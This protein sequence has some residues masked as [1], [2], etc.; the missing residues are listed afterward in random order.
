MAFAGLWDHW[1]GPQGD[2]I[3]SFTVVLTDANEIVRPVHERMPVILLPD[4]YGKWLGEECL[5]TREVEQLL[6]PFPASK[7]RAWP[8]SPRV[9]SPVNDDPTVL[10]EWSKISKPD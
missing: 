7:M 8:V 9:N 5:P 6:R 10:A 1:M 2:E 4:D 3:E